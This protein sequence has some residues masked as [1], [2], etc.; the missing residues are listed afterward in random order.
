MKIYRTHH[1]LTRSRRPLAYLAAIFGAML[2]PVAIAAGCLIYLDRHGRLAA[3]AFT[4]NSSFDEK[5]RFV[6]E[7]G[8]AECDVLAIGSSMTENNIASDPLIARLPPGTSYLNVAFLAAK[9]A[10]T[11][12]MLD[13]YLQRSHPK[14]V[15]IICGPMDFVGDISE[16][17]PWNAAD[18]DRYLRGGSRWWATCKTGEPYYYLSESS[19]IAQRRAARTSYW[20]VQF[21]R[22]GAVPLDIHYPDVDEQR[23]N[24]KWRTGASEKQF[25]AF[26]KIVAMLNDRGISLVCVQAPTR[27]AAMEGYAAAAQA[28]WKRVNDV[29][30]MAHTRLLNLELEMPLSDEYFADYS[31][32]NAA[33]A[34]LCGDAVGRRVAEVLASRNTEAHK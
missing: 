5:I 30:A 34:A 15:V 23:W 2:V 13:F 26:A 22:G 31:H 3:P 27:A 6:R 9:M 1:S 19:I 33:G 21:D 12:R 14:V 28:H 8:G 7:R 32:L 20:S 24:N 29:L 18:V 10:D 11:Q 17:A 25:A 4:G 16:T